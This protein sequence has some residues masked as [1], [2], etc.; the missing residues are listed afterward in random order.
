MVL[1]TLLWSTAGVVTRQLESTRSFELTF[2]RSAFTAAA[3]LVLL[4]L[5]Q[6][7]GLWRRMRA[8]GVVLWLS[9]ACWAVMFTCFMLA[10]TLTSVANVLI[11]LAL[12]P[13]LTALIAWLG[14]GHR[15]PARTWV[16]ILLAGCGIGWIYGRQIDSD[17]WTG[18]LVAAA[19]PLAGAVNWTLVQRNQ[20]LGHRLDLAPAVLVGAGL[21]AL[22]TLPLA[23]P[24]QAGAP[25][26]AWLAA[27]GLGQLA[28]PCLLSVI[29]ARVLSA[30]E[31]SLLA[32]LEVLFGI[33]LAWLGAGETPP[34]STLQGGALVLG[35]LL[36]NEWLAYRHRVRARADCR[37]LAREPA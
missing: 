34:P 10:M 5:W 3:L 2:W 9:G 36:L 22:L 13:L 31:M 8:A 26:L 1:V 7:P 4:P 6:G 30:T 25:D 29:C 17:G 35:A 23:W 24:L 16:A 20:Q 32:L 11:T 15:P 12:G 33:G 21:S 18:I 19:V 14:L 37:L 28:I 27:L